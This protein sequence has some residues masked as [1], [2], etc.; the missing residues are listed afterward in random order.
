MRNN[1]S[2]RSTSTKNSLR[3]VSTRGIL[4]LLT[5]K[6][7]LVALLVNGPFGQLV[8][9]KLTEIWCKRKHEAVHMDGRVSIML[10][11]CF[12]CLFPP[13]LLSQPHDMTHHLG[14]LSI[15][16]TTF[17]LSFMPGLSTR[18]HFLPR[19]VVSCFS[20][21]F[22]VFSSLTTSLHFF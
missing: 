16:L 9:M 11:H 10:S 7:R 19:F 21:A 14:V 3:S 20:R 17:D 5:Y 12:V 15:H 8:A 22:T 4:S 6:F 18:T 1:T 13:C 2:T